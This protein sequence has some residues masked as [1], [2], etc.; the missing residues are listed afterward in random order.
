MEMFMDTLIY[1]KK[2]IHAIASAAAA[3]SA[4]GYDLIVI[5]D[6]ATPLSAGPLTHS[7][8]PA[9]AVT[10]LILALLT[11]IAIWVIRR[12]GFKARLLELRAKAG[13]KKVRVPFTIKGIKD[14]VRETEKNLIL[15]QGE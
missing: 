4:E 2:G 5:D 9:A 11:I 1:L 10:I 6:E 13:D 12:N 15:V 7:Y 8:Y 3:A 14:E